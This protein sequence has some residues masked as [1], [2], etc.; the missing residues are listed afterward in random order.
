[1]L[2]ARPRLLKDKRV[3]KFSNYR[4]DL[5]EMIDSMKLSSEWARG[6][7]ISKILLNRSEKQVLLI[8]LHQ[9]TEVNSFQLKDSVT[10]QIIE[11]KLMFHCLKE[12]V[13]LNKDQ[14]FKLDEKAEYSLTAMEETMFLLMISLTP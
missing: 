11:G 2:Y 12:S 9:G 1:M 5:T 13:I 14:V 8:A 3:R 7:L 6:E 10:F 4:F